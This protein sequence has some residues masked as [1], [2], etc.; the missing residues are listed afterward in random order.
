MN[1]MTKSIKNTTCL[2]GIQKI[3][4]EGIV[5]VKLQNGRGKTLMSKQYHNTGMPNLFKFI[6]TAL[7]GEF[8]D[9]LRPCKIKLFTYKKALE[10]DNYPGD[11]N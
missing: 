11:F 3:S 9:A 8:T 4:Y 10:T 2:E 5:S 7:A 1:K 6:C